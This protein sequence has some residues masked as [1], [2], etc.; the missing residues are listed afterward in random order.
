[1]KVFLWVQDW[2]EV[3]ML[4]GIIADTHNDIEATEKAIALFRERGINVIAHA[5][6]ITSPRLLEYLKGFTCYI[7]LG[8]GD[9]IDADDIRAKAAALG[10]NPVGEMLEFSLDG[11]SFVMF[12]GND[13]PMYRGALASGKY[14]YI[15]KGHTHYFEN[16]VSNGCRIINPG[17]VYGHDESSVVILDIEA[18]R[19]EKISLDEI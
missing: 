7:V 1:M 4:L 15:I 6:D 16:Y 12:H 8:N 3:C 19:V 9:I 10:F 14:D 11:K 17:A 5:G 2:V 18:D 13:V